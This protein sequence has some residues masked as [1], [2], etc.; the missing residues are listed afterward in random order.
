VDGLRKKIDRIRL[1]DARDDANAE[2]ARAKSAERQRQERKRER[3]RLLW[4]DYYGALAISLRQRSEDY[5]RKAQEL[6]KKGAA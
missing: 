2:V 3:N 1:A 4:A 5:E 6:C